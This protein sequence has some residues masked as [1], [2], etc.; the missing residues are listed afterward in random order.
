MQS[1]YHD[2][3]SKA[4]S[5]NHH[6]RERQKGM[7]EFTWEGYHLGVT[8]ELPLHHD[9]VLAFTMESNKS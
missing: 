2:M 6:F 8:I 4:E 9:V 5:E 1:K 7:K 3:A